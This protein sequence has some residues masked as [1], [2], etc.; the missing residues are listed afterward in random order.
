VIRLSSPSLRP[1]TSWYCAYSA[2]NT[3]TVV[4]L[5]RSDTYGSGACCANRRSCARTVLRVVR[6][7]HGRWCAA[8]ARSA[9]ACSFACA[10]SRHTCMRVLTHS[11]HCVVC[12][13]CAS[14]CVAAAVASFSRSLARSSRCSLRTAHSGSL[15]PVRRSRMLLVAQRLHRTHVLL[16]MWFVCSSRRW[17]SI[18]SACLRVPVSPALRPQHISYRTLGIILPS[19]MISCLFIAH[20]SAHVVRRV[21]VCCVSRLRSA[22]IPP[23]RTSTFQLACAPLSTLARDCR[24]EPIIGSD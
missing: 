19:A 21:R 16:V 5:V 11:S 10:H 4:P 8:P 22:F 13:R 20:S 1:H 12:A 24:L 18:F 23:P 2:P 9:H 6:R 7:A 3:H 17:L 15:F 14:C